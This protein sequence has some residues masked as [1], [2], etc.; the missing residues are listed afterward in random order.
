MQ[1]L[2]LLAASSLASKDFWNLYQSSGELQ[3]RFKSLDSELQNLLFRHFLKWNLLTP[4]SFALFRGTKIS[5]INLA[6]RI[7][8][9]ELFTNVF[10][11]AVSLAHPFKGSSK[12]FRDKHFLLAPHFS[13]EYFQHFSTDSPNFNAEDFPNLKS[14]S[15]LQI[16]PLLESYFS[17]A[18]PPPLLSKLSFEGCAITDHHLQVIASNPSFQSSLTKLILSNCFC[19]T[20]A[21]I[22]SLPTLSSLSTLV[23]GT[24]HVSNACSSSIASMSNLTYLDI[25]QTPI[26][27]SNN[28]CPILQNLPRLRYFGYVSSSWDSSYG[29]SIPD[30]FDSIYNPSY[31]QNDLTTDFDF[32]FNIDE[33]SSDSE[34][35]DNDVIL[36]DNNIDINSETG[37]VTLSSSNPSSASSASTSLVSLAILLQGTEFTLSDEVYKY[38]C[39]QLQNLYFNYSLSRTNSITEEQ[40]QSTLLPLVLYCPSLTSLSMVDIDRN[41]IYHDHQ[42]DNQNSPRN[43]LNELTQLIYLDIDDM[44]FDEQNQYNSYSFNQLT[45]LRSLKL[46][47]TCDH[48]HTDK[49]HLHSFENSSKLEYLTFGNGNDTTYDPVHATIDLNW[50]VNKFKFLK[51]VVICRT[52]FKSQNIGV[53]E[54][55]KNLKCLKLI[56]NSDD[57][58]TQDTKLPKHLKYFSCDSKLALNNNN[59]TNNNNNVKLFWSLFGEN[60]NEMLNLKSVAWSGEL[61]SAFQMQHFGFNLPYLKTLKIEN[62]NFNVNTQ[63]NQSFGN[64]FRNLNFLTFKNCNLNDELIH[65]ISNNKYLIANLA[66]LTLVTCTGLTDVSSLSKLVHLNTLEL[67]KFKGPS[68][69]IP[70]TPNL[71]ALN[72][73]ELSNTFAD[74]DGSSVYS[75]LHPNAHSLLTS[76]LLSVNLQ[77]LMKLDVSWCN[78]QDSE[79]MEIAER[80]SFKRSL[81]QLDIS[82]NDVTWEGAILKISQN[83]TN[84]KYLDMD[85]C[86]LLVNENLTTQLWK[87]TN[88]V[89]IKFIQDLIRLA[90]NSKQGSEED[91]QNELNHVN[92]YENEED[93]NTKTQIKKYFNELQ[94]KQKEYYEKI[95]AQ[96]KTIALQCKN[97]QKE[98]AMSVKKLEG[99]NTITKLDSTILTKFFALL[100]RPDFEDIK[101][102]E[103]KEI[104]TGAIKGAIHKTWAQVWKSVYGDLDIWNGWVQKQEPKK[105][106]D[107]QDFWP[108]NIISVSF[109]KKLTGR[110]TFSNFDFSERM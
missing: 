79:M 66:L 16:R 107:I 22:L 67:T 57:I 75:Y 69:S 108:G 101:L 27:G 4:S 5:K 74:D 26:S 103:V 1:S 18:N 91:L 3:K 8:S 94:S 65:Y 100:K 81:I 48:R 34:E 68:F 49:N 105:I 84:L 80:C 83:F 60:E 85:N 39:S 76:Q 88:E 40:H 99:Q 82:G 31:S 11:A 41:V 54:E 109:R 17:W 6:G 90:L 20:D 47:Q 86:R 15:F 104:I 72:L 102:E 29:S 44:N 12:Q 56:W 77:N 62:T 93:S 58:I 9:I 78:I 30:C 59:N 55:L 64:P 33:I 21:S 19:I 43:Y 51:S 45:N 106:Y 2:F 37:I 25:S 38:A 71:L 61:D 32:S 73:R 92:E 70:T 110:I 42:N 97:N 10:E 13:P 89:K 7:K 53:L 35:G 28:L 52:K 23:L 24:P 87:S 95:W 36:V 96:F 14:L 63:L 46:G 98:I 50:F